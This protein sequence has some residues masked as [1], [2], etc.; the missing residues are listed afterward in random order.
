MCLKR[1][2]A[3]TPRLEHTLGRASAIV[4]RVEACLHDLG[5]MPARPYAAAFPQET[6]EIW[7]QL[8]YEHID[9]GMR[10]CARVFDSPAAQPYAPQH[11]EPV[12]RSLRPWAE[13]PPFIRLQT[14]EQLPELLECITNDLI[15]SLRLGDVSLDSI[16]QMLAALASSG[17]DAPRSNAGGRAVPADARTGQAALPPSTAPRTLRVDTDHTEVVRK[18]PEPPARLS[19]DSPLVR[20]RPW[21]AEPQVRIRRNGTH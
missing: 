19:P 4:T 11:A 8:V 5:A 9:G 10:I 21:D 15:L 2:G 20:L 12:Q 14:I 7:P 6:E 13:C 1:L 18:A 3:L 16:E 17:S